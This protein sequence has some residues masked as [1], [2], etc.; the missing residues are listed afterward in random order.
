MIYQLISLNERADGSSLWNVT[1]DG[2]LIALG[3]TL[4]QAVELTHSAMK[5]DD[6]YQEADANG[7]VYCSKP[8]GEVRLAK[9]ERERFY[10]RGTE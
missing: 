3:V 1:A 5:D 6:T 10:A 2:R 4:N 7:T 9:L 8:A